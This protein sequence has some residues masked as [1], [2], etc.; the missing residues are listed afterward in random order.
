MNKK[1]CVSAG[2]ENI[3]AE[4]I[5]EI[6]TIIKNSTTASLKDVVGKIVNVSMAAWYNYF[7]KGALRG[8]ISKVTATE[9]K[10][11]FGLS[12][13]V[14][15]GKGE[16]TAEHRKIIAD[17]IK[18]KFGN[19]SQT[20]KDSKPKTALVAKEKAEKKPA[21]VVKP[22]KSKP[23]FE[24]PVSKTPRNVEVVIRELAKEIEILKDS[25]QLIRL[26]DALDKL[27]YIALKKIDFCEALD[28]LQT[29]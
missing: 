17:K 24:I 15:T 22:K 19:T 12:E 3:V 11:F 26:A 25:K 13:D 29:L 1:Q 2:H 6:N 9:L 14:F 16:F 27:A 7:S 20:R 5:K 21:K 10:N 8:R 4:R 23:S 28:T 18:E